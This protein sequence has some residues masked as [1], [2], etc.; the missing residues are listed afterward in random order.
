MHPV[1]HPGPSGHVLPPVVASSRGVRPVEV[2]GLADPAGVVRAIVLILALAVA[3]LSQGQTANPP[4]REAFRREALTREGDPVRGAR[5]FAEDPRLGCARCH[6]VDG[7]A[8]KAGPDLR[9]VGDAFGRRDLVDAVLQP[10]ATISPGYGTVM[11]ETRTG[12]TYQG[13]LKRASDDGIELM[14]GDGK[15]VTLATVDLRSREGSTQS[16]MPEG[17]EATLTLREFTDLVE[18]LVS[19]KQPESALASHRGM[20]RDIPVLAHPVT[21]RPFLTEP[22]RLPP[23]RVQTG[24]TAFV[25]V[26]GQSNR[27][28]VLH[29][30]GMIWK[31]DH[32]A[33][34]ESRS[35][36]ADLTGLVFSER[37]PNGL[38]NL[39]FHPRC[40]ENRKYYLKY[41]VFEEG[42]VATVIVEHQ[43]S[44][45]FQGDSGLPGRRLLR[46]P[47]VAEDHSG[48]CLEF[49]P[50][51]FL[52]FA[53]GDTGP[54]H[55]PNG[56]AQNLNLLL[57]KLMRIDVDHREAGR[58][59]A[60]PRDNPWVGQAGARPE[61]WALGFRN[62]WRFCFDPVNGDL[63]L[64]D[65]GQD[66]EEEVALVR[67][68]ENHGWNVYEGFEPFSNQYR[69]EG[70]SFTP[71]VFAYGRKY[72]NSITGGRV[73][74][75]DPKSSFYGVYLCGD[76][77]SKRLFGLTQAGGVLKEVRQIG[78]V[79]Q[80][81]VSF[82][83]DESGRVFV[84][85]F[86]G[87]VY[88]LDFRDARFE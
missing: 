50:D 82:G 72:G 27:F 4:N 68:G 61:I 38:L 25:A 49:G 75:G 35:V 55:D 53:L 47:S 12:E 87:M 6:S 9:A 80:G 54:H 29:Q 56:H 11:V 44:A 83:T 22:L 7:S 20:P 43:M 10:S 15:L 46:I 2:R 78:T 31:V 69:Q 86:E 37:G 40:R 19:L 13:V 84:V 48:G 52:Y 76:Y 65:V 79:P 57:G 30:K 71:P 5:L 39:A 21:V 3:P 70:R 85:G 63:W 24:L 36:F 32:G 58:E 88:E 14:G 8:S 64:A 62:P 23:A 17:L 45:D 59:Y 28:L 26:P 66:R 16:L 60:I 33:G 18:Y 73:Y 42:R 77:T 41:Q 51:G 81:L 34:G 74:R 1:R 67:R